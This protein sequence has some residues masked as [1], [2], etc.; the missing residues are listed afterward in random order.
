MNVFCQMIFTGML[1]VGGLW[2][3]V[4]GWRGRWGGY[5]SRCP[6]CGHLLQYLASERCLECGAWVFVENVV[7]ERRRWWG[8]IMVGGV[9]VGL[10]CLPMVYSAWKAIEA[11]LKWFRVM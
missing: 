11:I 4:S 7:E 2:V 10:G 8:L 3:L 5:E 9:L 1:I 6:E